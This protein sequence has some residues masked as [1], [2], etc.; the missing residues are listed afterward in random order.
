MAKQPTTFD[1]WYVKSPISNLSKT[2]ERRYTK[3]AR[4]KTLRRCRWRPGKDEAEKLP[5]PAW[6]TTKIT[7]CRSSKYRQREAQ[8]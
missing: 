6:E 1:E 7:T 2:K 4:S 8:A 3:A 5:I